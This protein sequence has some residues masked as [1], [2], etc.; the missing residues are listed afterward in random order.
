MVLILQ[1]INSGVNERTHTIIIILFSSI[2]DTNILFKKNIHR[3]KEVTFN[4][5]HELDS[6]RKEKETKIKIKKSPIVDF[7]NL[8][9]VC[10]PLNSLCLYNRCTRIR[11]LSLFDLNFFFRTWYNRSNTEILSRA[12]L[13]W[14]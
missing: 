3:K 5:Y 6:E 7:V 13:V 4:E 11:K 10:V 14:P 12:Y 1:C 9:S 2:D 8:S